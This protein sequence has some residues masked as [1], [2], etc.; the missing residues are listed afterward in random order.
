M[1]DMKNCRYTGWLKNHGKMSVIELLLTGLLSAANEK[2]IELVSWTSLLEM[3]ATKCWCCG[4]VAVQFSEDDKFCIPRSINAALTAFI[5]WFD[6]MRT[7]NLDDSNERPGHIFSSMGGGYGEEQLMM[8][9][10]LVWMRKQVPWRGE[11]FR[12]M[13][14]Q[15]VVAYELNKDCATQVNQNAT[16]L[17]KDGVKAGRNKAVTQD[18]FKL[19]ALDAETSVAIATFVESYEL[20]LCS[21]LLVLQCVKCRYFIMDTTTFTKMC[22]SLGLDKST[23]KK[24]RKSWV[25]FPSSTCPHDAITMYDDQQDRQ[26]S[27][28]EEAVM[29]DPQAEQDSQRKTANEAGARS[30]ITLLDN[31]VLERQLA[32]IPIADLLTHVRKQERSASQTYSQ[33]DDGDLRTKVVK[34]LLTDMYWTYTHR[35]VKLLLGGV[36]VR[37][38][39]PHEGFVTITL[40]HDNSDCFKSGTSRAF[41][42]QITS[43]EKDKNYAAL[44]CI[45]VVVRLLMVCGTNCVVSPVCACVF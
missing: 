22:D 9:V 38:K 24:I 15:R 21:L 36:E 40:C 41:H 13:D 20:F 23:R 37:N 12:W 30:L 3:I 8:L 5:V 18:I 14:K 35:A 2:E 17:V 32:V 45:K 6:M 10:M 33:Y 42:V 19:K 7:I 26:Q 25:K 1:F 4:Y 28:S 34:D 39:P 43:K 44:V 27:M 29:Q 11:A 31:E 16:E